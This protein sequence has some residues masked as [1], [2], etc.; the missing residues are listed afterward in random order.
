MRPTPMRRN[1]PPEVRRAQILDA[2]LRCIAAKGYHAATMDD[3]VQASG[4]SKGSL[5][6]HFDSKEQVF[7]ALFDRYA[8]EIFG[9]W[10]DAAAHGRG[11][12]ES[13]R[14]GAELLLRRLSG[15][16]ALLGAWAEFLSHP[17]ARQ[18]YAEVLRASREQIA[19][20]LRVG[21]DRGEVRDLPAEGMAAGLTA[22]MEGMLLQAM[23]DPDFDTESHWSVLWDGVLRGYAP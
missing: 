2:A 15:E 5:Y 21:I 9:A 20:L 7:L 22:A 16:G 17:S 6:W 4:L 12:L 23:V 8:E 18:R 13:I 11:V 14:S 19:E 10:R 1:Q 3:L